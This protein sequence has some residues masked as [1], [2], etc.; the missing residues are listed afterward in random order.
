[1][2]IVDLHIFEVVA[3]S[4][5]FSSAALNLF[6]TPPAVMH[7][8]NELEKYLGVQLF[9]RNSQGVQLTQ[10]GK[11][12]HEHANKLIAENQRVIQLV[13]QNETENIHNI[14]IGSSTLNPASR[15]FN[16]WEKMTTLLPQYRLQFIPLEGKDYQFPDV[17]NH[18]GEQVDILFGP[19]GM[20]NIRS[21][22]N[23]YQVGTYGFSI[24]M[25]MGDKL[26]HKKVITLK[27]L[28]QSE[29]QTIPRGVSKIFDKIYAEFDSSNYQIR[30]FNTDAHYTIDTFNRFNLSGQY[31]MS[32]D[33]WNHVLPDIISRPLDVPY[34][35]PYGFITP[36]KPN[37]ETE[38]FVRVLVSVI[39]QLSE[40]K[41]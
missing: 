34:K 38:L 29:V 33:C 22:I 21:K 25:H 30:T 2:N 36:L 40:N 31:L 9:I 23:F 20:D 8:I 7:R 24:A 15:L 16:V 17:Y 19:S 5:S 26:S 14:R 13:R 4:G 10:T 27:D 18:L 41:S 32:L 11:I 28:N 39:G 35:L 12:L 1:M 6:M 37:S 3:K